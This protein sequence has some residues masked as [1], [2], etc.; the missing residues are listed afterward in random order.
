[1]FVFLPVPKTAGQTLLSIIEDQH[2]AHR[3]VFK[4]DAW[5]PKD[6][7]QAVRERSQTHQN[8]LQ[9]FYGHQHYGADAYLSAPVTYYTMLRDPAERAISHYHHVLR[10]YI[11]SDRLEGAKNNHPD[12]QRVQQGGL[13]LREY[14]S[15]G[16]CPE[17]DNGQTRQMAG[18]SGLYDRVPF[19][20]CTPAL[21]E[22]AKTNLRRQMGVVG[23]TEE[24]DASLLLIQRLCGWSAPYYLSHNVTPHRP[25]RADLSP[26]TLRAIEEQTVLDRQLYDFGVQLFHEQVAAQG[27]GFADDLRRFQERNRRFGAWHVRRAAL[28]RTLRQAGR[29]ASD[30]LPSRSQ[31]AAPPKC[32]TSPG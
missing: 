16:Y 26:D 14:V 15:S 11:L 19:G 27:P 1:M 6:A 32:P 30:R 3:S 9:I 10:K 8:T 29:F 7:A 20:E 2:T 17:M 22:Q 5:N 23:L 13:S 28:S 12:R 31:L 18:Q 21:L 4:Q 25:R 24:F